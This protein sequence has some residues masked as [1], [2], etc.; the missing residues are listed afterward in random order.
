MVKAMEMI[1]QAQT[2]VYLSLLPSTFPALR[3][4][5]E[6]AVARG[7]RIVVYSPTHL[8]LPG[9]QVVVSGGNE[10]DRVRLA[11]RDSGIG[12]APEDVSRLFQRFSQLSHGMRQANGTGLGL[13]ISK[14]LVDAHGGEIG[15]SSAL[16][17]GSTFWFALPRTPVQR[18]STDG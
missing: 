12:I 14:A 10:P 2:R 7:V 4:A 9:G 15:V 8:E 6:E 11:I 1:R 18:A 16:G 13:S 5:L 17:K 3:N